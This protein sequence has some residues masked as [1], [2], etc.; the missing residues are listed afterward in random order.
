ME[1]NALSIA[2]LSAQRPLGYA[3]LEEAWPKVEPGL[4]PFGSRVLVQMRT[5][6]TRMKSGLFLAQ[7]T[8]DTE[9]WNTQVAKVIALGP[10]AFRN[11]D[12]LEPWP[13]G[14]WVTE[15]AFVRV[16]KY[17]GDRWEVPVPGS[18]DRALFIMFQDRDLGGLITID[19]L[20]YE[21]YIPQEAA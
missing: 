19:P 1:S 8:R 20:T 3:S 11:R 18:S 10:L 15:G 9:K 7:E 13:E 17:A 4:K 12:T 21:A 2:D 5:P 16:P 14:A 6:M